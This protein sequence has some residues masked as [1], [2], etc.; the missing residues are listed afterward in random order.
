MLG[1]ETET[2]LKTQLKAKEYVSDREKERAREKREVEKER[3]REGR[4]DNGTKVEL[5][6]FLQ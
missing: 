1:P 6:I 4:G 5:T 3:E 2:V